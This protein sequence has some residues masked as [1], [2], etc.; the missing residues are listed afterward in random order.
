MKQ[1]YTAINLSSQNPILRYFYEAHDA[2]IQHSKTYENSGVQLVKN[3]Q[4]VEIFINMKS[5]HMKSIVIK[6][7]FKINFY[8]G[9]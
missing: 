3:F 9:H 5:G 1:Y 6:Q 4:N 7:T 2:A 8:K